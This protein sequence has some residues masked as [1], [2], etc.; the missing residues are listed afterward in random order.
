[1][2]EH[3]NTDPVEPDKSDPDQSAVDQPP[4]AAPAAF[5]ATPAEPVEAP[6]PRWRDRAFRMR[7]VAAVAVAG[8]ILGAAG[9]SV[10]T[11][12]VAGDDH[13]D[14]DDRHRFGQGWQP[15]MPPVPPDGR[16]RLPGQGSEDG[17]LPELPEMP[18]VPDSGDGTGDGT[19]EESLSQS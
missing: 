2:N 12:L 10:T 6:K 7:A 19:D 15:G 5:A 9:G 3:D 11:A 18:V 8:V 13:G 4:A 14:R 17:E 1:M 16:M